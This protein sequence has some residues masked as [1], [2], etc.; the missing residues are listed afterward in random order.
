MRNVVAVTP[1]TRHGQS[2]VSCLGMTNTTGGPSPQHDIKDYE[3]KHR[4]GVT[5]SHDSQLYVS[6]RFCAVTAAHHALNPILL[7]H[8]RSNFLHSALA[9]NSLAI[10]SDFV[11][12]GNHLP[13][14][15]VL[16]SVVTMRWWEVRNVQL[17][18]KLPA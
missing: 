16:G 17:D 7:P 12:R 1:P 8:F 18:G 4:R 3:L 2:S 14:L 13:F 6:R 15:S 11:A 10:N 9:I 5:H